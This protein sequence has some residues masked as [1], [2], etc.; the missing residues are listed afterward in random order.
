M[1]GFLIFLFLI[2]FAAI[3]LTWTMDAFARRRGLLFD[4]GVSLVGGIAVAFAL[5]FV[6]WG[7]Q[8]LPHP[9]F[10][11]AAMIGPWALTVLIFGVL[12]DWKSSSV[13]QKFLWQFVCA[14]GLIFFGGGSHIALLGLA[15]NFIFSFVWIVGLTNALNLLDV[16]DGVC[17]GAVI[18]ACAGVALLALHSGSI[19]ILFM[20]SGLAAGVAGFLF[21][22]IPPAKVYLG[23]AGSHFSGFLLAA[24]SLALVGDAPCIPMGL[25]I[26]IVFWLPLLETGCLV[27]FRL[28][29]KISP[30]DKSNDHLALRFLACRL[31]RGQA[32][33]AMVTLAVFFSIA[34]VLVERF[35][36]VMLAS[37]IV[38]GVGIVTVLTVRLLFLMEGHGAQ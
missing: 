17:S 3:G 5:V 23:N 20:A 2:F 1:P 36:T 18:A 38:A 26:L 6:F 15:G 30:F 29:K 24:M 31:S 33:L 32:W 21:F 34:G 11:R 37:F 13:L 16:S 4:R 10:D 9:G 12:D 7:G 25:G 19:D 35:Y 27:Y 22:N 14:A 28:N 8:F